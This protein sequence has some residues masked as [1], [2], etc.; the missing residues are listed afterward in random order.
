M[1]RRIQRRSFW[2]WVAS[3][4]LLMLTSS[5]LAYFD[6]TPTPTEWAAWPEYCR[7]QYVYIMSWRSS[8]YATQ[9]PQSVVDSW[10]EQ[11]GPKTFDGLHH[12]CA[13]MHYLNRSRT[14]PDQQA[15]EF[16]LNQAFEETM[17]TY[18][19]ADKLSPYYV[20]VVVSLA[21]IKRTRGEADSAITDL[22]NLLTDHPTA[23]EAYGA[24][25]ILHRQRG[26]LKEAKAVLEAGNEATGGA[27]AELNYNLGLINLELGKKEEAAAFARKA[28]ELG[29]PFPALREKLR[30]AGVSIE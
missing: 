14:A 13:G 15:R 24:L 12:Y 5:A 25:A 16:M 9:Y 28:Y 11:I 21:S 30:A 27:S 6:F 18:R 23:V 20:K 22:K 2:T 10:R 19:A 1:P 4:P 17:Y 8:E 7:V 26:R 3:I 29:H